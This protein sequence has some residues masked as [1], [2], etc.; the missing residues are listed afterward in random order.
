MYLHC[1]NGKRV[2]QNETEL[3]VA[4]KWFGWYERIPFQIL[5]WNIFSR[6]VCYPNTNQCVW[7]RPTWKDHSKASRV[8]SPDC[9][10]AMLNTYTLFPDDSLTLWATWN[11]HRGLNKIRLYYT[12]RTVRTLTEVDT[13]CNIPFTTR[14]AGDRKLRKVN[15]R[16]HSRI[17]TL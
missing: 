9:P 11:A 15:P 13:Y 8:I 7:G 4:K 17:Y 6:L 10:I 3:K 12:D 14:L 5:A 2:S 16:M 1:H